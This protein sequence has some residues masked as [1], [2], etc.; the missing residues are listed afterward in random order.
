MELPRFKAGGAGQSGDGVTFFA[1]TR[2]GVLTSRC[3]RASSVGF[4]GVGPRG[5]SGTLRCAG[6]AKAL[7]VAS[8]RVGGV[9]G[10]SSKLTLEIVCVRLAM[11]DG[12]FGSVGL[13]SDILPASSFFA[14]SPRRRRRAVLA[15][16]DTKNFQMQESRRHARVGVSALCWVVPTSQV[17]VE[18]GPRLRDTRALPRYKAEVLLASVLLPL[19]KAAKLSRPK[20]KLT[21]S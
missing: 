16:C 19:A 10:A 5:V 13:F 20:N 11:S 7:F 8:P 21:A 17:R 15:S 3:E 2:G 18:N 14:I 9:A 4:G 12:G 6:V 1:L